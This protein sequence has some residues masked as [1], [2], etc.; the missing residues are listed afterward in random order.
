MSKHPVSSLHTQLFFHFFFQQ[1]SRTTMNM[2]QRDTFYYLGIYHN[3]GN[4]ICL[5]WQSTALVKSALYHIWLAGEEPFNAKC[6]QW[7]P[8]LIVF[9]W[10]HLISTLF[11]LA[12]LSSIKELDEMEIDVVPPK[13][14]AEEPNEVGKDLSIEVPVYDHRNLRKMFKKWVLSLSLFSYLF[15]VISRREPSRFKCRHCCVLELSQH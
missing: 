15:T 3:I 8:V 12:E 6:N 4:P 14:S 9:Q 13:G 10:S 5:L 7:S 2:A 1:D 11:Q